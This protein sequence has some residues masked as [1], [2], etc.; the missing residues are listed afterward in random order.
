M[1]L[2][3]YLP[4]LFF[5]ASFV[6]AA[7]TSSVD[8]R[9]HKVSVGDTADSVFA[10][11][12]KEDMVSQEI[13]KTANGLKLTKHYKVDGKSFVLVF[14]RTSTEGPY[15]VTRID[16]DAIS[17]PGGPTAGKRGSLTSVKAFEATDFYRKHKPT[18]D[19]WKVADGG[20]YTTYSIPDTETPGQSVSFSITEGKAGPTGTVISWHGTSNLKPA[21]LTKTKEVFLADFLRAAS[22]TTKAEDVIKYVKKVGSKNYEEGSNAMP[23]TTVAGLHMFSGSVGESL[24]VG[25][26]P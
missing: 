19:G 17:A 2:K 12:K 9:G 13:E 22:P 7:D 26:E 25:L 21:R 5:F 10:S 11:L 24:M 20:Y 18:K 16:S 6:H 8:A 14:A 4:V 23:R 15:T 1:I 3:Q